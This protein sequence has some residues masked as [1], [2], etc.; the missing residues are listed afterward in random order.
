MTILGLSYDN[1]RIIIYDNMMTTLPNHI[2][3]HKLCTFCSR[4]KIDMNGSFFTFKLH[5]CHLLAQSVQKVHIFTFTFTLSHFHKST[6]NTFTFTHMGQ[7]WPPTDPCKNCVSLEREKSL[8]TVQ[9][10]CNRKACKYFD[11]NAGRGF[12]AEFDKKERSCFITSCK[13]RNDH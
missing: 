11:E 9:T 12:S 6:Y 8:E 13:N 4:R 7:L 3:I 1:M 2:T 10:F 5:L